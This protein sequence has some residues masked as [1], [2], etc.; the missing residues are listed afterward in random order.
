MTDDHG[1]T[2][3]AIKESLLNGDQ[4][5]LERL[6]VDHY[7]AG[8]SVASMCDGGIRDAFIHIGELWQHQED[9]I[10]IEH[11]AVDTCLG[12]LASLS[13]LF[14]KPD[15]KAPKALWREPPPMIPTLSPR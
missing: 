10:F 2:N 15:D 9:G 11:R 8:G 4:P 5:A 7:A 13:S 3:A 12:A 14:P 6:L 1:S